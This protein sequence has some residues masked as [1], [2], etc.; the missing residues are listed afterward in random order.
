MIKGDQPPYKSLPEVVCTVA[1]YDPRVHFITL[2]VSLS[3]GKGKENKFICDG[4]Q[5]L[6]CLE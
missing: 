1:H 4:S 2:R 5:W 3:A 6:F